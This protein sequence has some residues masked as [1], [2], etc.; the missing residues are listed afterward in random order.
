[1]NIYEM[2]KPEAIDCIVET[3]LFETYQ[4]LKEAIRDNG[5]K[6]APYTHMERKKKLRDWKNLKCN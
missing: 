3:S 6:I 5:S 1:M 2:L 4:S